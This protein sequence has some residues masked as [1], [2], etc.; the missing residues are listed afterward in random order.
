MRRSAAGLGA[1]LAFALL[2][3][4]A[5]GIESASKVE[6]TFLIPASEGYGVGDC[7]TD[8]SS[9]C[10]QVVAN[11]WCEAQGFASAGSFGVAA[12]DEY[13]GA[14]ETAPVTKRVEAP[15]RITCQ[16]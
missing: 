16:D 3:S 2:S 12:Q 1:V 4:A 6:K 14:I 11:A 7:L 15:I 9:A 5:L 8:A 10:G 13:T